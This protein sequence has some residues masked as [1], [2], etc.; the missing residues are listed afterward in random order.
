[1]TK[2]VFYTNEMDAIK[3]HIV[4][5]FS[6]VKDAEETKKTMKNAGI[7]GYCK[8]I[9]PTLAPLTEKFHLKLNKK[10]R[11]PGLKLKCW[12]ICKPLATGGFI[13]RNKAFG[14]NAIDLYGD[15]I[16]GIDRHCAYQY[17]LGQSCLH[18]EPLTAEQLEPGKNYVEFATYSFKFKNKPEY[19]DLALFDNPGA[20]FVDYLTQGWVIEGMPTAYWEFIQQFIDVEKFTKKNVVYF[21][22]LGNVLENSMKQ[23][24]ADRETL[25]GE[26]KMQCKAMGCAAVGYLAL[27]GSSD[28]NAPYINPIADYW[29]CWRC[30]MGTLAMVKKVIDSGGLWI[31]SITDSVYWKGGIAYDELDL[32]NEYGAWDKAFKGNAYYM[33]TMTSGYYGIEDKNGNKLVQKFSGFGDDSK[34]SKLLKAYLKTR[35]LCEWNSIKVI[36]TLSDK[37]VRYIVDDAIAHG[38]LLQS[39][40]QNW[41]E[42]FDAGV[43]YLVPNQ[44][45]R[46]LCE[47]L[48]GSDV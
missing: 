48:G 36:Q 37:L 4:R 11:Y 9:A 44:K 12:N 10:K 1:M 35:P 8:Y 18:P 43:M 2:K 26:A 42:L 31:Q 20:K 22:D 24:Y 34:W 28:V 13:R 27:M 14:R 3:K 21:E 45:Y 17:Y 29:V 23:F 41:E 30:K 6:M 40:T 39:A 32:K 7:Q 47:K 16:R 46:K 15:D 25:T 33:R 38:H 5:L 19:A